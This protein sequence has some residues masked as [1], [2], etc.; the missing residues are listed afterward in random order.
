MSSFSEKLLFFS[1]EYKKVF[2]GK[3]ELIKTVPDV[4]PSRPKLKIDYFKYIQSTEG[5]HV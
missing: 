2:T 3:R 4:E 5:N 1:C